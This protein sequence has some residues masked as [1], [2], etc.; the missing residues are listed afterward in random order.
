MVKDLVMMDMKH[1]GS[2]PKA[3]TGKY[4]VIL[5][6]GDDKYESEIQIL[7]DPRWEVGD[8]DLMA[9]FRLA[10][11]IADMI[12]KSQRQLESL[13]GVRKQLTV[14]RNRL[15]P[16]EDNMAMARADSI[17]NQAKE[18]EDLIYQDEIEVSQDEIN[19]QRLFTNHIVRLYRVVIDQDNRPSQGELE[20]WEDL[21]SDYEAFEKN[22][23]AFLR[24][25]MPVIDVLSR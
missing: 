12:S 11:D 21:K 13:R 7:K 22:Y 9:N 8:Q 25:E 15:D 5:S 3:P 17:I 10:R 1:P 6:V 20:R 14:W 16:F 2:G 4:A 19:Y 24:Q 23:E 18:V